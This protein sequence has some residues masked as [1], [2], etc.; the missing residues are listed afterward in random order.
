VSVPSVDTVIV[1]I[2]YGAGMFLLVYLASV[3]QLSPQLTHSFQVPLEW[4]FLI[5]LKQVGNEFWTILG[6]EDS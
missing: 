1:R 5:N 6:K 3:I 4:A 2:M